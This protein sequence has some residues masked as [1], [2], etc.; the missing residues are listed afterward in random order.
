MYEFV[1]G[2]DF[3]KRSGHIHKEFNKEFNWT[4][5]SGQ[6]LFHLLAIQ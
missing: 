6:G 1:R 2:F 4:E 3:V 5:F